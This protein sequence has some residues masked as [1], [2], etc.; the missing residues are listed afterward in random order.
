MTQIPYFA[1]CTQLTPTIWTIT[2]TTTNTRGVPVARRYA[3]TDPSCTDCSYTVRIDD[4]DRNTFRCSFVDEGA[5]T[6]NGT[7]VGGMNGT[8]NARREL[9][10]NAP[11]SFLFVR[12]YAGWAIYDTSGAKL[13]SAPPRGASKPPRGAP[14]GGNG[15]AGGGGGAGGSADSGSGKIMYIG[16]GVGV[17][18]AAVLAVAGIL[19][20]RRRRQLRADSKG[21]EAPG[22]TP[23]WELPEV[24]NNGLNAPTGRHGD[25]Y[26]VYALEVPE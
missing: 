24:K 26:E 19:F 11:N 12:N 9:S 5:A 21:N 14:G 2:N 23:Y 18:V 7:D 3:C 10:E 8:C 1:S 20:V 16:I 25:R 22:G 17:A 13:Q 15:T 4:C 6:A